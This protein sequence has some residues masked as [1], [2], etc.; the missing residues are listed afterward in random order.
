MSSEFRKLKF[1]QN[2]VQEN[3]TKQKFLKF[4]SKAKGLKVSALNKVRPL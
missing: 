1:T 3:T 2:T 4:V